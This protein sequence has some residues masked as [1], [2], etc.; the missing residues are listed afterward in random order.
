MK[1]LSKF[2]DNFEDYASVICFT[3]MLIDI[4]VAVF[5]RYVIRTPFPTGEEIGRYL[6]IW[7]VFIGISKGTHQ[8]AHLGIDFLLN[9]MQGKT[10]TTFS[11]LSDTVVLVIYTV[12][13]VLAIN[14]VL[15]TK[16]TNQLTPSTQIPFYLI[17]AAMPIGFGLSCIRQ[18]QN[19]W[20]DYI[21]KEKVEEVNS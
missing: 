20:K 4:L 14:M 5:F 9:K 8:R 10:S 1:K 6:M 7:G 2:I 13:F 11:I 16:A 17:Y 3:L 15:I 19:I 12:S 21:S 18:I